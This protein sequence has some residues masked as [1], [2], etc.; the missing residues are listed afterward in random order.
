MPAPQ[1]NTFNRKWETPE[2]L[3]AEIDSYFMDCQIKFRPL[4][5]TGLALALDTNRQTL[6][7]YENNL[8]KDFDTL[9]KGAKLMCENYADE[10][11]YTGK[12]VAGAIFNLKNNYNWKDKKEIDHAVVDPE[13]RDKANKALEEF[14]DEKQQEDKGDTT[15][16]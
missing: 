5:I 8:G 4:T 10:Y 13:I 12:N 14:L 7:N 15:E 2:E 3:K 16:E 6:L 11:L 1:G 9:I